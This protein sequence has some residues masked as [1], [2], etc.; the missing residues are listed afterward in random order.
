MQRRSFSHSCYW[1]KYTHITRLQ[2]L[3]AYYSNPTEKYK[4]RIFAEKVDHPHPQVVEPGECT[5]TT[6][7]STL[8]N[9]TMHRYSPKELVEIQ[10][11][12]AQLLTAVVIE[13]STFPYGA[14][15]LLMKNRWLMAHVQRLQSI[16]CHY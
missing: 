14:S 6:P 9:E 7:D 3:I 11:E 16:K 5:L 8:P 13:P 10:I 4:T 15:V 12:V 1:Q 2:A